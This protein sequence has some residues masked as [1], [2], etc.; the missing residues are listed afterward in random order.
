LV[1]CRHCGIYFLTHPRNAGRDDLGCP[2]GCREV[3]RRRRS[4]ERST[5]YYKTEAG[6]VKK[7]I[8]NERRRKRRAEAAPG[9]AE[10]LTTPLMMAYL[11]M[12]LTIIERRRIGQEEIAQMLRGMRQH[13]IALREKID[14]I[15]AWLKESSP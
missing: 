5:E 2:F 15:D 3:Y 4:S 14:Y 1:R 7:R 8:Q 13:S 11:Q 6:R 9:D 12:L 10:Q